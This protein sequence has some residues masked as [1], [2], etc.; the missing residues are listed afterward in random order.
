MNDRA[1]MTIATINRLSGE[2][3]TELTADAWL[4]A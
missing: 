4:E 2:G 1:Q 3:V